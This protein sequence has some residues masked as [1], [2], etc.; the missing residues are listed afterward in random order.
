M[1]KES[2][3]WSKVDVKE[4]NECWNYKAGTSGDGYGYFW[5][6]SKQLRAHRH[7][8]SIT[9]G[10]IPEGKLCLHKCDNRKCVNPKHLYIGTQSDNIYDREKRNGFNRIIINEPRLTRKDVVLIKELS[11]KGKTQIELAKVFKVCPTTIY[12]AIKNPNHPVKEDYIKAVRT[13]YG[14]PLQD[15]QSL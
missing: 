14:L 2:L 9:K 12:G 10:T 3:F 6:G 11:N 5:T 1:N 13:H 15:S 8:W 7:S 4:S